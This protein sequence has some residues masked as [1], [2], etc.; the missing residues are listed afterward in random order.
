[1]NTISITIAANGGYR[2]TNGTTYVGSWSNG[3]KMHG[4]G[5]L[6]F[7][8]GT[9]YDGYFQNGLFNGL[10]VLSFVD[11]SRYEGEFYQGWFHGYGMFWRSDCTR[12]E[13]EFR[14]GK[15]Y[16]FGVT[17]Y[18]DNTS[19]FPRNEGFFQECHLKRRQ[20]CE[21]V[22]QKAQKLAFM[23]RNKFVTKP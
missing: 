2:F 9:R 15:V 22:I 1:M 5:H 12:H 13:G 6:L 19:G 23:A 14:G 8:D 10:G 20:N 11:G 21:E 7:P 3:G 17:T 4:E 18:P 16:G